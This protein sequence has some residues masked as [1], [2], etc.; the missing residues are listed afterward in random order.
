MIKADGKV[1]FLNTKSTTYAFRVMETGQLE[2]MYYGRLINCDEPSVLKEKRAFAPGNTITYD[3]AHQDLTLEDVRLELSA[4]GKGDLREPMLEVVCADGS[5]SLDFVYDS[6]EVISGKPEFKTLPSSYD[7]SGKVETL[8]VTMKDKNHGF[9]LILSYSVFEECDVITRSAKFINTSDESVRLTRMLSMLMDYDHPGMKITSFHGGW[10]REMNKSDI[11]LPAGKFVNASFTGTSSNRCNPLFM[12]SEPDSCEESGDVWGFNLLYSGNHYSATEVSSFKKTRVVYG[13]N[14]QNFAWD[15]A[16]GEEF[17]APEAVLTYSAAGFRQMS[18]NMHDFVRE[19]ITRGPWKK[20]ERP[21]LINSWEA[22]YFDFTEG[23]LL[24]LAKTAK[25]AG[26]EL[27]VMDDGWF[28]DRNDDH[29]AL[30]DWDIVNKKKLPGGLEGLSKKVNDLGLMFGLWVEPEMINVD[31]ELYRKHPDWAI[32]IP[33]MDHSEGRFQRLLDLC[34]PEVVDY[35]IDRMSEVFSTPGISYIKWDMNRNFSDYYSKYLPADKQLEVSHRYVLGFYRLLKTL[36]ER[37]PE[38]LMEGCA[39]GG[40]RFDLGVLCYYPQIWASDNTD[41]VSRLAI[42]DG[43]SYGYPQSTYTAHVSACPNHQ[44][45]RVTPL[46]SRFA[47]ASFGVLGYEL[48][49][50]DMKSEDIAAVKA[51]IELYK[52]YRK[53]LQFGDFYRHRADNI[54]QW[55]IVD[56]DKSTSV[57]MLMQREIVA[58]DQYLKLEMAGLD[59]QTKYH[60]F[61]RKLEYNV[62]GFGDLVNTV[63]PI[64][65]KQDSLVHN[66]VA[67]FVKMPGE[68]EDYVAYGNTLNSNGVKLVQS[69]VG[70]GFNEEVRYFPDFGARLYFVEKAE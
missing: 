67:K 26:A 13:I 45:L 34:N 52:Q 3:D 4:I 25:N 55:S 35:M 42:Q 70:T 53:T 22:S 62:K 8:N 64:H 38:I 5:T 2:H 27:F 33:N 51:Q 65:I 61:G 39:S 68:I 20:K 59:S 40:N 24:K 29:R 69:F 30:G 66:L 54:Y 6:Y 17:E 16:A 9:T 12:I 49:L 46:E 63:S 37:F 14:P 48:N 57:S 32:D 18:L 1:F 15:L 50:N 44:T 58:G 41:A 56:K 31:S 7:E 23:S 43:Y 47:V 36:A 60:F 19:H 21:V 11:V 10:T 28:G